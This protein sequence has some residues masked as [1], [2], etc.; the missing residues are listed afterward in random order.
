MFVK[1]LDSNASFN[2]VNYNTDK[3]DTGKGEFLAAVNFGLLEGLSEWRPQDFK[4]FFK[5]MAARN[6]KISKPQFHAAISAKGREATKEQLLSFSKLWMNEMGY[7]LQ[8]YLVVFHND[9]ENNHVHIV[10][11]RVDWNGKKINDSYEWRRSRIAV[12][13][14]LRQD[15]EVKLKEALAYKFTTLAQFK[16]ILE[17]M[18][19]EKEAKDVNPDLVKFNEPSKSR[20]IQLNAIFRKYATQQSTDAFVGYMRAKMG[21]ELIFHSKDGKPAYGYTVIDHAQKNAYKGSEIMPLKELLGLAE[22]MPI[23]Y[24]QTSQ[25]QTSNFKKAVP[26]FNINIAKDIDDD[27]IHGPRRRRK[28]KARTNTR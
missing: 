21:V 9:T 12:E 27:Q 8:P 11:S 24:I 17:S 7:G 4:N 15:A 1:I 18:G 16:L 3:V 10:S 13:K 2:G 14:I 25:R 5:A 28:K 23:N 22:S 6:P 20:A 26:D 19:L